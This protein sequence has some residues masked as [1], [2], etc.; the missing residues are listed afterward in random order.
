M[1]VERVTLQMLF[2]GCLEN[3]EQNSFVVLE[4]KMLFFAGT[5]LRKPMGSAYVAIT[6]DNS[7]HSLPI[8]FEEVT[9]A[10]RVY[11]SGESE[12]LINGSACRR[13]DIVELFFDTGIGKEGYSII[14]Q[15]QIE[16]ILSGKPEERRE[17]FD[18]A[19]GI[20]KYKKNK[21]ETQK[22][23]EIERENLV[24]VTDILT[25]LERQ[26]G[27]LKK[28]SERA[29]EY[30]LLRDQLKDEDVKLFLLENQNLEK[31]LKELDEKI[32]IAQR[33]INEGKSDTCQSKREIRKTRRVFGSFK[34]RKSK[35]ITA[36][37][38]EM[39][40]QSRKKERKEFRF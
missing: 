8:Q 34:N 11:R 20:V 36:H 4:W 29:R 25:E 30:L 16:Q 35:T 22:S 10:R 3:K 31:E 7:D 28:Q 17:L 5:E 26:V 19:A 1:E 2:D 6:L 23:L 32:E 13:K 9:V 18:E 21:L 37:I 39:S 27:P 38:S 15:G 14:G 33:E 40:L 12:Y 24:R